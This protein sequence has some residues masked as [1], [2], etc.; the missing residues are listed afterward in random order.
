MNTTDSNL[1]KT[2]NSLGWKRQE[3]IWLSKNG[4]YNIDFDTFTVSDSLGN[5]RFFEDLDSLLKII[6]PLKETYTKEDVYILLLDFSKEHGTSTNKEAQ[7]N[8]I[9]E[10]IGI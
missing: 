4:E 8:W 2:L 6:K 9:K 5:L 7:Y 3:G 10:N 1:I